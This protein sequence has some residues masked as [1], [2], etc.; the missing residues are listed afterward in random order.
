MSD[1]RN[2][3]RTRKFCDYFVL[4]IMF[5]MS[6][7]S[8]QIHIILAVS[9][10]D[11]LPDEPKL[12][13]SH[14]PSQT[15][16]SSIL[17]V[18]DNEDACFKSG[19]IIP[20]PPNGRATSF[21]TAGSYDCWRYCKISK[22]CKA[23]SFDI[24]NSTC[25]LLNRLY[26]LIIE[27]SSEGK[28]V[29]LEKACVKTTNGMDAEMAVETSLEKGGVL[30]MEGNK[31]DNTCLVATQTLTDNNQTSIRLSWKNCYGAEK[32]II[33][34]TVTYTSRKYLN[35]R[36]SPANIPTHCLDVEYKGSIATAVLNE[37]DEGNNN[38][39]MYL[40]KSYAHAS[41]KDHSFYIHSQGLKEQKKEG[42]L[43]LSIENNREDYEFLEGILFQNP[44]NY[45]ELHFCPIPQL[46]IPHGEPK[47]G[48]NLPWFLPGHTVTVE[49][50]EGYGV[51][52]LNVS[53][54]Q[55]VVC[56]EDAKPKPCL[57]VNKVG[58]NDKEPQQ[59][60][61]SGVVAVISLVG[62]SVAI[63]VMVLAILFFRMKGTAVVES[64]NVEL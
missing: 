14:S 23:I 41:V 12:A 40:L 54:V 9:L 4:D 64:P 24:T 59:G 48:A 19:L 42:D 57:R 37:C 36:F 28:S 29:T 50:D 13:N 39:T 31:L 49:C 61:S 55:E 47:N 32:W 25:S 45:T 11:G 44:D 17:P 6:L 35:Y 22:S 60:I 10:C 7:L 46:S 51:A 52:G 33:V 58:G 18:T 3:V 26:Q 2:G 1:Y 56:S 62:G 53:P 30:I 16:A 20:I 63:Y 15:A 5:G 8:V 21:Q 43:I 34:R 38:Q 27:K